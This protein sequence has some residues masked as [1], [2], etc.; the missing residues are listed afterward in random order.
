MVWSRL[1]TRTRQF[2]S[3][4]GCLAFGAVLSV[5]ARQD[6]FWDTRNYHLYNA[7]AL[8][9]DRYAHDITAAGMQSYFNPLADL[10][11]FILGTGPLSHWPRMLA[12]LQGLWFGGLLFVLFG[13]ATTLARLQQRRFGMAD[14][15]A[16]LIGASGTMAVSQIGSTTQE[17]SLAVFVLTGLWL[18]LPLCSPEPVV[19]P[20]Y[21]AL[22]AGVCCGLAAG[23]KPT[24]VVYPPAMALALLW[25]FG[26]SRDGWKVATTYAIGAAMAFLLSYGWWGWHLYQLTGNPMFPMFNQIFHS[27]LTQP[28]GGTDGQFRPRDIGQW[29]FYPFYWLAKKKGI[30]GEP[31]FADPRYAVAM[32]AVFVLAWTH[33]AA[34][35]REKNPAER[36]GT[37]ALRLVAVFVSVAYVLWMVLFSIL[38][39][40]VP[41]EAMT[42]L[43]MLCAVYA[44]APRWW[45]TSV[46]SWRNGVAMGLLFGLI[47]LGT[48]YPTWGRTTFG[49]QVFAVDPGQVEPGS[50]VLF[51]GSP[52]AY[53]A[54]FFPNA[55]SLDFIGL[56]WFTRSSQGFGLWQET[57][58]KIAEHQG[59]LY[60][61]LR[62]GAEFDGEIAVLRDLLPGY[63][64]ASC[65]PVRSN[66]ET[67]KG[68]N[69]RSMGLR[70]CRLTP[71]PSDR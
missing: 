63:T 29:L 68:G 49:K 21:R 39:Y 38:R 56:T 31:T 25:A 53:L 61:T 54:P 69:D 36:S 57:Q 5:F 65:N 55:A 43:L 2:A 46:P 6:A 60:A 12:A 8:L 71:G 41:I 59:A 24:A 17:I 64:F 47:A 26:F 51:A 18:L 45:Q 28:V 4:A 37:P 13:I 62:D 35:R 7:W 48:Y 66:L 27:G 14:I 34:K 19:R 11:Y 67:G 3:L 23:L 1:S 33:L 15:F 20:G 10:P 30:V 52:A 9:N 22:L 70:L 16:V 32:L 40:A 42:G 44:A 58:H 50:L